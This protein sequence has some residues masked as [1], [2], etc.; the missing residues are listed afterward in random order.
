[1][2]TKSGSP[3][4]DPRFVSTV[5]EGTLDLPDGRPAGMEIEVTYSFDENGMMHCKFLDVESGRLT[6]V[7]LDN[8]SE[9]QSASEIDK[10]LVE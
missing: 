6:E 4:T 7:D 10:F 1:M 9:K 2:V 5:W 8:S 3:E